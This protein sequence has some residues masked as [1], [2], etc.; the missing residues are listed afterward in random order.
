MLHSGDDYISIGLRTQRTRSI[1]I[2]SSSY[3]T[4]L[5]ATGIK[6]PSAL[7]R[8]MS[9]SLSTHSTLPFSDTRPMSDMHKLSVMIVAT[10]S[11]CSACQ[12]PSELLLAG[13]SVRRFA[14]E[15]LLVSEPAAVG[16]KRYNLTMDDRRDDG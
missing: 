11:H 10:R 4:V 13:N 2:T 6:H 3:R 16:A 1:A 12:Y 9:I 5:T 8:S 7:T 14:H 15:S